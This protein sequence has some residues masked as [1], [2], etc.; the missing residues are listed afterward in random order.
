M[1]HEEIKILRSQQED[2]KALKRDTF[3]TCKN[4]KASVVQYTND[5]SA[6]QTCDFKWNKP[7]LI[8]ESKDFE[9]LR[10]DLLELI[11]MR[12][13]ATRK[14]VK[15]VIT[16]DINLLA[17]KIKSLKFGI[18]NKKVLNHNSQRSLL[19]EGKSVHIHG[20]LN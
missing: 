19:V 13:S 9:E 8:D 7:K 11:K 20:I 16:S 4:K 15:E 1:L 12:R 6:Q 3:S 17:N 14:Y 5:V 18:S 10:H 2:I